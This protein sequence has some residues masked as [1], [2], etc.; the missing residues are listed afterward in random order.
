MLNPD[1]E[2]T[3][4]KGRVSLHLFTRAQSLTMF[5]KNVPDGKMRTNSKMS[6]EKQI[7]VRV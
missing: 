3:E 6:K 5:P 2:S 7:P 1:I 4:M